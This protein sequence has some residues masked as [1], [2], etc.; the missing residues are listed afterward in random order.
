MDTKR[1]PFGATCSYEN[2][3]ELCDFYVEMNQECDN[4]ISRVTWECVRNA[5]YFEMLQLD[6]IKMWRE[7]QEVTVAIR[8]V[9]PWLGQALID[10]RSRNQD[11]ILDV[12]RYA[13]AT[14]SSVQENEKSLI[15]LVNETS[16]Y[17]GSELLK[18]NYRQLSEDEYN[19]DGSTLQYTLSKGI[20]DVVLPRGFVVRTLTEVFDFDKLSKL[21]WEGFQ[22]EGEIPKI[23]DEVYPTIKHA[24]LNYNRE[25]CSVVLDAQGN[26][27]SFCGF[28]YDSDT[29]TGFLEPMV[30][31]KEYRN[32]G[33]GKAA[34]YNSLKILKEYGCKKAFVAP[35]EEP[36][37]YYCKLG[38]ER[39]DDMKCYQKTSR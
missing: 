19:H 8:A 35:D 37:N 15:L 9:S 28:W 5:P 34:V 3:R 7:N 25:I 1:Q 39:N 13:E 18:Q 11:I 27:A 24:W 14:F 6:K 22:Y 2:E 31:A 10:N 26:Y 30:T 16:P 33:L 32:M 17:F 21:C 12:I 29:K 36:F 38:F 4:N 23:D 20:P